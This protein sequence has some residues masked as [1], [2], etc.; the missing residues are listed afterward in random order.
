MCQDA[1]R[2]RFDLVGAWA[3]DRLGR[4]LQDLVGFVDE[5]HALGIDLY[6]H[7]Q[8]LD[9]STP[10]VRAMFGM[11][12]QTWPDGNAITVYVFEDNAEVHRSFCKE[13]LGMLPYPPPFWAKNG[14]SKPNT[15]PRRP[16]CRP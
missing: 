3:V 6:L 7:Q 1:A 9:T 4:S 15:S 16:F 11:R 14:Q 8:G 2:R 12:M 10:T 13:I 5:I